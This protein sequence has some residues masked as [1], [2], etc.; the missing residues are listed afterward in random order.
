MPYCVITQPFVVITWKQWSCSDFATRIL[1]CKTVC[2]FTFVYIYFFLV[3]TNMELFYLYLKQNR[4]YI[5]TIYILYIYMVCLCSFS[6]YYIFGSYLT[7]KKDAFVGISVFLGVLFHSVN[8]FTSI[9]YWLVGFWHNCIHI[10]THTHRA[11]MSIFSVHPW[12]GSWN[13]VV[14]SICLHL[15]AFSLWVLASAAE[16]NTETVLWLFRKYAYVK[17]VLYVCCYIRSQG[18][19]QILSLD[20]TPLKRNLCW[21]NKLIP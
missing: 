15:N 7:K 11:Q 8:D 1:F 2:Y 4:K 12:I 14:E 17:Q 5:Y 20:C 10:H 6:S 19:L 9:I 16:T 3:I 21:Q 13:S 18:Q